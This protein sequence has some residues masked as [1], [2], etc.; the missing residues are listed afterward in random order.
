MAGTASVGLYLAPSF[1]I[2]PSTQT[3]TYSRVRG[4]SPVWS[5]GV[6]KVELNQQWSLSDQIDIA[7]DY[8]LQ[9][10]TN[11]PPSPG[12]ERYTHQ[13][14]TMVGYQYSPQDYFETDFGDYMGARSVGPGYAN[15]PLLTLI[16]QHKLSA[17]GKNPST[18]DFALDASPS[19]AG[20]ISSVILTAGIQHTFKK[21]WTLTG[22][23]LVGLTANDPA[24]GV[25]VQLQFNGNLG[26]KEG[27]RNPLNFSK[28]Q[29]LERVRFGRFGRF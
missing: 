21:Y 8:T 27:A 20:A 24:V 7:G 13:F 19:S 9:I 10:A 26:G 29:R 3:F 2:A 12:G 28:L 23:A 5:Y 15:T 18:L 17:D 22:L 4:S 11:G 16:G 14:L 25:S 1:F 6:T